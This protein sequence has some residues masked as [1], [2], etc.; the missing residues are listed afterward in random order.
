MRSLY[1][2][3]QAGFGL[4]SQ[5]SDLL[6]EQAEQIVRDNLASGIAE[7][8]GT[9]QNLTVSASGEKTGIPVPI[10]STMTATMQVPT[11]L[12]SNL[13]GL[14]HLSEISARAV[15]REKQKIVLALFDTSKYAGLCP[16]EDLPCWQNLGITELYNCTNAYDPVRCG[17]PRYQVLPGNFFSL[18]QDLRASVYGHVELITFDETTR[19]THED[20]K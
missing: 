7:N 4:T 17:T 12:F 14:D 2:E 3:R 16:S 5:F 18:Y 19:I 20:A 15:T 10:F 1:K 6:L 13:P 11:L 9:M 8:G